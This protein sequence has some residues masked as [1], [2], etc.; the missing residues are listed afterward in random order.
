MLRYRPVSGASGISFY[1]FLLFFYQYSCSQ[2]RYSV[3]LRYL[4]Y[5]AG[6][7]AHGRV[8]MTPVENL[9]PIT[10]NSRMSRNGP[11]EDFLEPA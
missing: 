2:F 6:C 9:H 3:K 7:H 11:S 10:V 5:N 8:I 4:G 1:Y